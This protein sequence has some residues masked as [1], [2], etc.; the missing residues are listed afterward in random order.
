MG[1]VRES[2]GRAI[3][4]T[5]SI[6]AATQPAVKRHTSPPHLML[7]A[8]LQPPASQLMHVL[9]VTRLDGG[10]CCC[11]CHCIA[12][13]GAAHGARGHGI[14][15]IL[16]RGHACAAQHQTAYWQ[17][18][19]TSRTDRHAVKQLFMQ[20]ACYSAPCSFLSQPLDHKLTG[21][22]AAYACQLSC[23][24]IYTHITHPPHLPKGSRWQCLLQR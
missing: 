12:A 2:A 7:T 13:I 6:L 4:L 1:D 22:T 11:T 8:N 14:K 3:L 16:A 23:S 5:L 10:H 20:S 15:V 9:T 24:A 18:P 17:K 19:L 21:P